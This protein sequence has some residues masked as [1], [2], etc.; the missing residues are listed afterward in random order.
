MAD[1]RRGPGSADG[2]R[3]DRW[4]W[5]VR[6]YK[7]RTE[8]TDAC[9]AGHV[10]VNGS[11]AKAATA[12]KAGDRVDAI[13]AAGRRALEVTALV[14]KRSSPAVAR[15]SYVDHT[16]P[17]LPEAKDVANFVRDRGAGRPTKRDRRSI[18]KLL[19]RPRLPARRPS[20][21]RWSAVT[22]PVS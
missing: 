18:D 13:T 3:V 17:P 4:L 20:H 5:G 21:S 14:E 15:S 9:R 6:A 1:E 11:S 10:K 16:P 8:A 7:T 19:G 22:S 2:V 12:V